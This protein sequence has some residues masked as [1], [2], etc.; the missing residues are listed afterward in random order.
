[1]SSSNSGFTLEENLVLSNEEL[2]S[3]ISK[4]ASFIRSYEKGTWEVARAKA[5]KLLK[6]KKAFEYIDEVRAI[7]SGTAQP[8]AEVTVT[9]SPTPK[10]SKPINKQTIYEKNYDR[11]MAVAPGLEDRLENYK[12]DYIY[13]KSVKTGYMDFNLEVLDHDKTGFYIAISHY[14]VQNG[15]M[16]ADPDMEILVDIKNKTI[17]ALH[18]QDATR[19][20]EVYPDK[21][22]R[23]LFSKFQK[24]DQNDFLAD[25]LKNLK[26]QGHKIKWDEEETTGIPPTVPPSTPPSSP[27]SIIV[28]NYNKADKV[29]QSTELKVEKTEEPKATKEEEKTE[30]TPIISLYK[31]NKE[32]LVKSLE[33]FVMIVA[34]RENGVQVQDMQDLN[35]RIKHILDHQGATDYLIKA[36]G[37]LQKEDHARLKKLNYHRFYS[38]LPEIVEVLTIEAESVRL[39]SEKSKD[40]FRIVLGDDRNKKA[41]VL[42]IY[43]LNGKENEPTLLVRLDESKKQL[44]VDMALNRFFDML[45]FD[46]S[47]KF[48]SDLEP[49]QSSLGLE[50]WLE[51]LHENEYKPIQI[52]LKKVEDNSTANAESVEENEE[53]DNDYINKDIPDFEVGKVELTEAHKKRG[54]TQKVID[55][56]NKTHK[57]VVLFPRTQS[58][59]H[60]TKDKKADL[61]HQAQMPGFRLSKTGKFYYEGRSNRA[62]R[63]RSGY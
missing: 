7:V 42:G 11:L 5:G 55:Y 27:S 53:I 12:D 16:V 39:V 50:K 63:T 29:E 17:E 36:W 33:K 49:Y 3:N 19:Y 10:V 44:S 59:I 35:E 32:E 24:K 34:F 48:K 1:M 22:N 56:I 52:D 61:A 62:D 8:K 40:A 4:L 23:D 6:S 60:N 30:E 43:Q 26:N 28:D 9:A 13:G 21:R 47:E 51:F 41:P 31:S 15:D 45:T 38:I 58:M 2:T 20:I 25:W 18:F 37:D 57:G 46:S 54:V 14:Y